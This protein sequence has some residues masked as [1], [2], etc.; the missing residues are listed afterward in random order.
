MCNKALMKALAHQLVEELWKKVGIPNKQLSSNLVH[1]NMAL[2]FEAAKVG[3]VEFL[4]ILARSYPDLIWQQDENKMSIFHIAILHRHESVFNLIFEIGA[5][6]DSLA[7]YANLET[8]ENML[9]LA[10]NLAPSDQLNIVSGAALQMQRE[11]LW[12]KVIDIIIF[13]LLFF[14]FLLHI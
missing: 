3:N 5:G 14:L 8:K 12:F 7:S 4:I 13:L 11:L 10:G 6:K 9:H 2:I 1:N